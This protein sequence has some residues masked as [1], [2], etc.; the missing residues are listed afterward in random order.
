MKAAQDRFVASLKDENIDRE[1]AEAVSKQTRES[2]EVGEGSSEDSN[3]T[4]CALCRDTGSSSQLCFLTL[5]QVIITV[6]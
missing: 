6:S 2:V 1:K 4:P 5:V 3:S